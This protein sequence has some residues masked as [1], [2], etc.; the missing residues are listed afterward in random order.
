M[1]Q[2]D[3]KEINQLEQATEI[4]DADLF[5]LKQEGEAKKLTG[6]TLRAYLSGYYDLTDYRNIVGALR[7]GDID[8]I[9]IGTEFNVTHAVYGDMT[10][11]VRAKNYI[12]SALEPSRPTL[13]IQ[14]KYLLSVGG[15]TS[16]ATFQ[17]DRPEAFHSVSTAIPA[18]TVVKFTATAYGSWA[19]G[20]YNF[21]TTVALPVGTKLCLSGYQ[22]TALTSL[23]V[24]AYASAKATTA[25]GNFAISSGDGGATVDLGTWQTN[26]NHPQRISY[27]SNN[28]AQSNILQFLNGDSGS[29]YMDS[30]FTPKTD[31]DMMSTSFT[32]LKGFL[33]GFDD[34]FRNCLG[35][36]TVPTISNSVF[37]TGYPLSSK[38]TYNATFWLPSRKEVYGTNEISAE[39]DEIQFPYYATVGTTD[40]DKLMYAKDASS[41]TTYWLRTPYASHANG[42]RICYTGNGGALD[43][44]R[45]SG[46]N[47]VAPL[48]I[49]A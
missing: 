16:A 38:Y 11:I 40:A 26:N 35:V 15:G 20:T 37:E 30:I 27:G 23:N 22:N 44:N 33:G 28:D 6:S 39:N 17:F 41:P 32:S 24:V 9:P 4:Q 5:V 49:L 12:K 3:N 18:N 14:S 43:G 25:L 2:G 1:A 45:A 46:T 31:W 47:A 42:V 48:A 36:A 8:K 29:N 7:S 34:E 19:A 13:T 21:T 10:F